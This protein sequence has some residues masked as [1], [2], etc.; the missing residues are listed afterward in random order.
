MLKF[1]ELS[2]L[3]AD[4]VRWHEDLPS[5]LTNFDENVPEFLRV[6]RLVMKWRYQNIR[7]VLHRPML[8]STALRRLPFAALSAE[9][10]VAVGKCRIIA[11]K[12]IEDIN[13][14]CTPDLVSG[15]N[16]VWFMFQACM[17]PLVSL[18]SD[19][20][21]P[22]EVDKWRS[23]IDTALLFFD[24]IH[25]Y[26]VAAKKSRDAVARLYEAY[27][28]MAAAQAEAVAAQV[29]S[30]PQF[31]QFTGVEGMENGGLQDVNAGLGMGAGIGM[32]V[33]GAD[34]SSMGSISSF[35]DNMMWDTSFPDMSDNS[36]GLA[37]YD[38]QASGQGFGTP[39]WNQ[40]N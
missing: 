30:M 22:D 33:W 35:W 29:A 15:W 16:G 34:P 37:D 12:T 23:Q 9:E 27:K 8:L 39:M 1:E 11:G 25:S 3:D 26:S 5:I 31:G 2:Q 28:A 4:V 14:E 18:F 40:G 24:R 21:N 38:F 17:V 20:S 36:F 13:H 10:K 19:N 6:P 7:I 32:G